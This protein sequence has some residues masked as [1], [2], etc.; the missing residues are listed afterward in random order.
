MSSGMVDSI[1]NLQVVLEECIG[2]INPDSVPSS[3]VLEKIEN[4]D[5]EAISRVV[6]NYES[7][8]WDAVSKAADVGDKTQE[9]SDRVDDLEYRMDEVESQVNDLPDFSIMP[10]FN[11]WPDLSGFD[12]DAAMAKVNELETDVNTQTTKLEQQAIAFSEE[13][14]TIRAQ[15]E[16]MQVIVKPLKAF[17][18]LVATVAL[19]N[20]V[21]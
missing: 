1:S 6:D 3:D 8:D 14:S 21:D 10:D 5:V 9:L 7:V 19:T 18:A 12:P 13:L 2:A 4:L 17:L 20:K 11:E 15:V 16:E